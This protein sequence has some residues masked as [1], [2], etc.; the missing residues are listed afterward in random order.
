[1]GR[2]GAVERRVAQADVSMGRGKGKRKLRKKN[3]SMIDGSDLQFN[4]GYLEYE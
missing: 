3:D 4:F 2:W 1:V